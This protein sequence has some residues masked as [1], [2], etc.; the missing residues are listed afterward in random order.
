MNKIYIYK[1]EV[2]KKREQLQDKVVNYVKLTRPEGLEEHWPKV[3]DIVNLYLHDNIIY[4]KHKVIG[5][6]NDGIYI[7]E[8]KPY[9]EEIKY[10]VKIENLKDEGLECLLHLPKDINDEVKGLS[11][12][13]KMDADLYKNLNVYLDINNKL[14][15]YEHCVEV[16]KT[17]AIRAIKDAI[18]DNDFYVDT[19]NYST[20]EIYTNEPLIEEVIDRDYD[21]NNGIIKIKGIIE[22]EFKIYRLIIRTNIYKKKE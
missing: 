9:G 12:L 15:D 10:D 22:K 7:I 4:M 3:G 2:L 8:T 13:E 20:I 6:Q 21:T 1:A 18:K 5:K 17:D 11:K 19:D 14:F 16:I